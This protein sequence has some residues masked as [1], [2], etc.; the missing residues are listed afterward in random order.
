MKKKISKHTKRSA[1]LSYLR[2][3]KKINSLQAIEKFGATRLPAMIFQFKEEGLDFS[4]TRVSIQDKFG[5]DCSYVQY[6]LKK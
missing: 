3:Y 2:K 1:V 5:K 6:T 4:K